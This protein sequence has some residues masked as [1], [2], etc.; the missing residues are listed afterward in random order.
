MDARLLRTTFLSVSLLSTS[1]A[2]G[3]TLLEFALS[4]HRS[5][6][7]SIRQLSCKVEWHYH[8]GY[9]DSVP[10]N[11]YTRTGR[12]WRS[13]DKVRAIRDAVD[14]TT[15]DVFSD[16]SV[17]KTLEVNKTKRT[18]GGSIAPSYSMDITQCDAYALGLFHV[19]LPNTIRSVPL[20]G[21]VRQVTVVGTK[22]REIDGGE[23]VLLSFNS[24]GGNPKGP[25]LKWKGVIYLDATVNYL[26]RRATLETDS[27]KGKF[28]RDYRIADFKEV[29][30]SVF[31][32]TKAIYEVSV[33]GKVRVTATTTISELVANQPLPANVFA[34]RFIEGMV[35]S[36]SIRG[37]SYMVDAEGN[38][39]S[40]ETRYAQKVAFGPSVNLPALKEGLPTTD[41]PTS[42][43]A[44][45]PYLFGCVFV[46]AASFWVY[47]RW[48]A[49]RTASA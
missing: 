12:Y 49:R 30:P 22:R 47:S 48:R 16:A 15:H 20:D 21:L 31:F 42:W 1:V 40:P 8:G 25:N 14:G 32:P 37:A 36:D 3:D 41:E 23:H 46:V 39:I 9:L 28:L 44:W 33:N 13:G 43:T 24:A 19:P 34:F 35:V 6:V 38:R 27:E 26:V 10:P 4:A 17:L 2:R 7:Q 29:A 45:L 11:D 18:V 5:S